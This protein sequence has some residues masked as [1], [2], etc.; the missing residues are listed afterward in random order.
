MG[1]FK[2]VLNEIF[3]NFVIVKKL[4]SILLLSLYLVS[5]TELYQLLKMPLLIEHYFQHKNLNS[6]MSFTAFLK[7]HYDHPVKDNDYDQDQKLP[8]VSHASPLSVAFTVNPILDLHFTEKVY[9]SIEIKK[10]FYKSA[11]YNKE[12]L[13]S[14][15]EPPKFYQ[16]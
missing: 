15:W 1:L 16:S 6:E 2:I 3:H 8:F 4:I 14:I 12:I 7:M 10:T 5:T 11:L 13:N 9:N